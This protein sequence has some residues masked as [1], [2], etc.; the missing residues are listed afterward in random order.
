MPTR[1]PASAKKSAATNPIPEEPPVTITRSGNPRSLTYTKPPECDMKHIKVLEKLH[2]RESFSNIGLLT[3]LGVWFHRRH[4]S[5]STL[6]T[7]RLG[8]QERTHPTR[9][10]NVRSGTR[11]ESLPIKDD[12]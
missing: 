11:H 4:R 7:E 8:K 5:R 12:S 3:R 9:L 2:Q 6:E 10:S 1:E